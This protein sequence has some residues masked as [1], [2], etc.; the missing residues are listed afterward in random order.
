MCVCRMLS[1]VLHALTFNQT[2][3]YLTKFFERYASC[4]LAR[5][6]YISSFH[7][8]TFISLFHFFHQFYFCA[9]FI[10][11][12]KSVFRDFNLPC[13]FLETSFHQYRCHHCHNFFVSQSSSSSI[14][15]HGYSPLLTHSSLNCPY[16]LLPFC[17]PL[18]MG[19][20]AHDCVITEQIFVM[21]KIQAISIKSK[22]YF[23]T[24]TRYQFQEII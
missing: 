12:I 16:I 14:L 19:Y 22:Q 6:V 11:W 3:Y 4:P 10:I 13:V 9:K 8:I 20:Q 23:S 17:L 24:W 5:N 7:S 2:I 15:R 18:F 21:K 1:K